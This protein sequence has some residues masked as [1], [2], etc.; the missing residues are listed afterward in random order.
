MSEQLRTTWVAI[1]PTTVVGP[2]K[3][4]LAQLDISFTDTF[5]IFLSV[6]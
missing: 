1:L 3:F 2:G 4:I 6:G 5:N